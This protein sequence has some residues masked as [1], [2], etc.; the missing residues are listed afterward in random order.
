MLTHFRTQLTLAMSLIVIATTVV[1]ILGVIGT[2]LATVAQHYSELHMNIGKTVA[3]SIASR[4]VESDSS[5]IQR[6]LGQLCA[7]IPIESLVVFDEEKVIA[8]AARDTSDTVALAPEDIDTWRRMIK[9]S[10]RDGV[11]V[12]GLNGGELVLAGTVGPNPERIIGVVLWPVGGAPSSM[13]YRRIVFVSA[14]ALIMVACALVI[15]AFLS[16]KIS[17]PLAMLSESVARIGSG[18]LQ[19]RAH[20][21]GPEELRRLAMSVNAM[22]ESL[23]NYLEVLKNETRRREQ[24]ETEVRLAS[25]VQRSV[26]PENG[27]FL[28][29]IELSGMCRQS[30]EIGGDFYDF[31]ALGPDTLTVAVGDAVGKGL[32]AAI[33]AARCATLVRALAEQGLSLDRILSGMN[34]F[35]CRQFARSGQFVTMFIAVVD[36]QDQ[37]IRYSAAGHNPPLLIRRHSGEC[38]WLTSTEGLPLGIEGDVA[39]GMHE[40]NYNLGDVLVLY[41]DGVTE[42]QDVS[43]TLYG[44]ERLAKAAA[45]AAEGEAGSVAR[46]IDADVTDFMRGNTIADDVT[47]VVA[48]SIV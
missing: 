16:H 5:S 12:E 30:K 6:Y 48:K 47:I 26:L 18:D 25:E 4:S 32:P 11:F 20:I 28:E 22:A 35:L 10:A 45:L 34:H 2:G 23:E 7:S 39:F 17:T 1:V 43:N 41:T 46:G 14:F 27:T 3:I 9:V 29:S 15:A 31:F 36:I 24:L 33:L 40:V 21:T 42:A 19:V 13:I 44:S 38:I 8:S 37:R